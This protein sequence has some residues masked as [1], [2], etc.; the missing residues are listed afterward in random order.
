MGTGESWGALS[1]LDPSIFPA[2]VA[3]KNDLDRQ[4]SGRSCQAIAI[5]RQMPSYQTMINAAHEHVLERQVC[6]LFA[7]AVDSQPAP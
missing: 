7:I 5:H 4:G 2:T 3:V 1:Q 6:L